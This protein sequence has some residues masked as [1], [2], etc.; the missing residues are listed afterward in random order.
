MVHYVFIAQYWTSLSWENISILEASILS[1]CQRGWEAKL[2]ITLKQ[3]RKYTFS[4]YKDETKA[5]LSHLPTHPFQVQ[6]T[7]NSIS[8]E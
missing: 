1:I 3:P 4:K 2:E 6:S 7:L 5:F 8:A